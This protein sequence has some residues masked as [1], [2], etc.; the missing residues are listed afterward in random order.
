MVAHTPHVGDV[1]GPSEGCITCANGMLAETCDLL[2]TTEER[3]VEWVLVAF[4]PFHS[5]FYTVAFSDRD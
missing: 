2:G 3:G 5:L 4:E 1:P